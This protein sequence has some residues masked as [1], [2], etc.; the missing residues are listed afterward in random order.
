M[1]AEKT[2]VNEEIGEAKT[3]LKPQKGRSPIVVLMFKGKDETKWSQKLQIVIKP[4][5]ILAFDAMAILKAIAADL[6]DG[7]AQ[8][9]D[10]KP[11][12]NSL[13]D[14][15][16][17]GTLVEYWRRILDDTDGNKMFLKM[18]AKRAEL[19]STME[20]SAGELWCFT[21]A[22]QEHNANPLD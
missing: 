10:L 13:L 19:A 15:H 1:M 5:T 9:S 18:L 21:T 2:A 17:K 12:K 14:M 7:K 3:V 11:Q 20:Q 8:L 6:L 16:E 4:P 22:Q